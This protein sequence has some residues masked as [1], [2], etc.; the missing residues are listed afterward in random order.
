MRAPVF[1]LLVGLLLLVAPLRAETARVA[2]YDV[3]LARAGPGLLLHDLRR[4]PKPD[5][6]AVVAV[7]QAARPDILL[8]NGFDHDFR[9]IALAAFRDL[10]RQGSAGIDYTAVLD[11]PVNAGVPTGRDLDG[12]GRTNGWKDARSWGRFPGQGG[13][14]LLSRF[15]IQGA[16]TFRDFAWRDLPGGDAAA[17]LPLATR[18][19]W[20]VA[21]I[22]P[23]GARLRLLAS[24]PTAPLHDGPEKVNFRR[25]KDE[26]GFWVWYL[27]G[28]AVRDDQGQVAAVEGPTVLL[29]NL[30]ADPTKGAGQG[31]AL[32]RLLALGD[33]LPGV[34]TAFWAGGRA[35][36]LDYVL[37]SPDLA[38]KGAG[39][40]APPP[41]TELGDLVAK[42]PPHRL[43]WVDLTLP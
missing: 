31:D 38:V 9:G 3:G 18:S 22:L 43:V 15:P 41:G 27:G 36:R 4:P 23:D 7:I 30:N 25:N 32:R 16:R 34:D 14:A 5:I 21:V 42:G 39:V 37:P 20:D 11:A 13:M 28:A 8:L 12:D 29:G 1:S 26:I 10:L 35:L 2:S 19:F 24:N 40:V 17:D 33:P 6:A